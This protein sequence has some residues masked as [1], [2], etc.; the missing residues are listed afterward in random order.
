MVS[1]PWFPLASRPAR[2]LAYFEDASLAA[3]ARRP[4]LVLRL[5]SLGAVD[6]VGALHHELGCGL[7]RGELGAR[8][9]QEVSGDP[10]V[11]WAKPT[12]VPGESAPLPGPHLPAQSRLE[13]QRTA[14]ARGA[15]TREK[16]A[17]APPRSAPSLRPRRGGGALAAWT[18]HTGLG[19]GFEALLPRAPV[20]IW[21]PKLSCAAGQS[22]GPQTPGPSSARVIHFASRV[23]PAAA[24]PHIT[25]ENHMDVS[26]RRPQPQ[27]RRWS[28]ARR[29]GLC[30]VIWRNRGTR[31]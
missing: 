12:S 27:G 7:H 1:A 11:G 14:R 5:D 2:S 17:V 8:G 26:E 10:R 20:L 16:R 15:R 31:H 30:G 23:E 6:H 28:Q 9:G 4:V 25:K 24:S 18:V 22:Y 19:F 13:L 29:L 3:D 21:S